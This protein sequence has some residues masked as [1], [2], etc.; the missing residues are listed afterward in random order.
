MPRECC[1]GNHPRT[2]TFTQEEPRAEQGEEGDDEEKPAER[3][4][5][6]HGE[7]WG[8]KEKAEK[9]LR[10]C[11]L[12]PLPPKSYSALD[13]PR[14]QGNLRP[15]TTSP[16]ATLSHRLF[17]IT[18]MSLHR[19]LALLSSVTIL[20]AFASHPTLAFIDTEGLE[21]QLESIE[22]QLSPDGGLGKLVEDLE[23][24]AKGE[25]QN[26]LQVMISG[27]GVTIWDV[28]K[29]AWFYSPVLALME[30]R[31][32]SGYKDA[33]G[34]LTGK[35]GPSDNVTREQALKIA[36]GS[37]GVDT[38]SCQGSAASGKVSE[39]AK[40]YAVCAASMNFGIKAGTDLTAPA[41]RA[42]VLHYVLRAFGATVPDGTAPFAD[43]K[44]TMYEDDIAY[45]YAL[46]IVSGDKNADGSL[47]YTFRPKENVN[48]AETAKMAKLA[49]ELL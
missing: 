5:R 10:E 19:A 46:G 21:K 41:S 37:A 34:N 13:D 31:V 9:T 1:K 38:A 8:R 45:A 40:P 44:G 26:Y 3:P 36:L 28:P 20:L 30:L 17:P 15:L 16:R 11:T 6:Q 35:Y 23:E 42:E 22:G 39:W 27:K 7:E 2:G 24:A 33:A 18:P 4:W 29:D 47:K 43:S 49:I 25:A 48:R 14:T 32:V 12:H